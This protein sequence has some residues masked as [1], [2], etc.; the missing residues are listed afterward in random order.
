[1]LGAGTRS[2]VKVEKNGKSRTVTKTV[3]KF[4][5]EDF[6]WK[7]PD[8]A[9][10]AGMSVAQYVIGGIDRGFKVRLYQLFRALDRLFQFTPHRFVKTGR[11]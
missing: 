11:Y 10:K 7:D 4:V 1:M 9:Q 5:N 6:T 2:K 3:T 8:A